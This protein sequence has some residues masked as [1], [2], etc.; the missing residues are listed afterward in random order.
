MHSDD[1]WLQITIFPVIYIQTFTICSEFDAKLQVI[2]QGDQL[3]ESI[4]RRHKRYM[5]RRIRRTDCLYWLA[6]TQS[7]Y[8]FSCKRGK[9]QDMIS[10]DRRNKNKHGTYGFQIKHSCFPS[11]SVPQETLK[12]ATKESMFPLYLG[13]RPD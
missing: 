1:R 11:F 3:R 9:A 12:R 4:G 2:V 7:F 8:E 10:F 5:S 13:I 6:A